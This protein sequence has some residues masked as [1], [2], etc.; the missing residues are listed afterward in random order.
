M[1]LLPRRGGTGHHNPQG[2][3]IIPPLWGNDSFN[4]GA[5]QC[6][7]R[8]PLSN[9]TCCSVKAASFQPR[10]PLT[11]QL[12][13]RSSPDRITRPRLMTGRR[14]IDAR[15]H[16]SC[17]LAARRV[18][19]V[20]SLHVTLRYLMNNR[21]AKGDFAYCPRNGHQR[22]TPSG[23]CSERVHPAGSRHMDHTCGPFRSAVADSMANPNFE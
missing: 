1:R 18:R 19:V 14:E 2:G 21:V 11:S 20:T 4:L 12:S 7:P 23:G 6:T 9:T 8:R 3:Y 22:G 16:V 10:R 5:G 17:R 13:S 15:M